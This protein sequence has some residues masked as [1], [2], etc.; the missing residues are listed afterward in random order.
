MKIKNSLKLAPYY[1]LDKDWTKIANSMFKHIDY[2]YAFKVYCYLCYRY[3][4]D[5]QYAFPT[6][7]TIASDCSI[8]RSTVQKAIE[9]L[10]ERRFIVIYKKKGRQ[11]ANCCYYVRY[12]VETE[13]DKQREQKEIIEKFEEMLG[14]E[15]EVEVEIFLDEKGKVIKE[16]IVNNKEHIND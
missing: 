6:L 4:R 9:Y 15:F 5:Y 11:W 16:E 12:V 14:D 7:E 8:A 3:N 1:A 10:E 13:E 2:I